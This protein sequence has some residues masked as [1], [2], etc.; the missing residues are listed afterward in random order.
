MANCAAPFGGVPCPSPFGVCWLHS[1][2]C[3]PFFWEWYCFPLCWAMMFFPPSFGWDCFHQLPLGGVAFSS[4]SGWWCFPSLHHSHLPPH[5]LSVIWIFFDF[6]HV[7][8]IC[9]VLVGF[10][11]FFTPGLLQTSFQ[12]SVHFT[13]YCV[14]VGPTD[15][16][17]ELAAFWLWLSNP[18]WEKCLLKDLG[19]FVRKNCCSNHNAES[20]RRVITRGHDNELNKQQLRIACILNCFTVAT[21]QLR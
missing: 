5:R 15:L 21:H 17:H 16:I 13:A 6:N 19:H 4:P 9:M 12:I 14:T 2:F 18:V 11:F 1:F 10:S 20:Q 8:V 3:V 7:L